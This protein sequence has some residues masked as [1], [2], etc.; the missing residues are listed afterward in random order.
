MEEEV[1]KVDIN[2]SDEGVVYIDNL[3]ADMGA[4]DYTIEHNSVLMK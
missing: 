1:L 3:T 4:L 2:I